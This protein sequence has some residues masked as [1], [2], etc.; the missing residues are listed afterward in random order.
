[1]KY[2]TNQRRISSFVVGRT[3]SEYGPS[4]AVYIQGNLSRAAPPMGN[5]NRTIELSTV[6]V[7]AHCPSGGR[8][9]NTI[10]LRVYDPISVVSHRAC[11]LYATAGIE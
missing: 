6:P 5:R 1:M 7:R 2:S 4:V 11:P 10:W 9:Y 3:G 8:R